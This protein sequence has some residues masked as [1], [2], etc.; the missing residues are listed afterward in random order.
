MASSL[1]ALHHSGSFDITACRDHSAMLTVTGNFVIVALLANP[2][3]CRLFDAQEESSGVE[4][5]SISQSKSAGAAVG[6]L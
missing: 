4:K 2:L 5:P 3:S 6:Y 1:A